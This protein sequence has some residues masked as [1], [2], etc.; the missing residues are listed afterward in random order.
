MHPVGYVVQQLLDGDEHYRTHVRRKARR[1]SRS[2]TARAAR[3]RTDV[4]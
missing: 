2:T 3:R 4:V 1:R